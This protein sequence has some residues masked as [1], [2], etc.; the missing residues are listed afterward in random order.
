MWKKQGATW[1]LAPGL[2]QEK[3]R[4]N[5][6]TQWEWVTS[7]A[8]REKQII[9]TKP[10]YCAL[11]QLMSG[12]GLSVCHISWTRHLK[13]YAILGKRQLKLVLRSP[14][15]WLHLRVPS[16]KLPHWL[17]EGQAQE[18]S[19]V[20]G[21]GQAS[22]RHS[23]WYKLNGSAPLSR[24][25]IRFNLNSVDMI[26][27]EVA[28]HPNLIACL[29]E[30]SSTDLGSDYLSRQLVREGS[31]LALDTVTVLKSQR[32]FF[33]FPLFLILNF[34]FFLRQGFKKIFI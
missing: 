18:T 30:L 34:F 6:E 29:L 23:E 17:G 24:T 22:K 10:G 27:P 31:C 33:Y 13:W 32:N 11:W 14:M 16:D 15:S 2:G 4:S 8:F 7:E 28:P 12:Y 5:L 1:L 21:C 9:G 19:K 26:I 25:E 3:G 20:R